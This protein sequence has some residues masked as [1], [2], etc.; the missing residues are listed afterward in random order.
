MIGRVERVIKT[1]KDGL[2]MD[3]KAPVTGDAHADS[4]IHQKWVANYRTAEMQVFY[5]MAFDRI[6]KQV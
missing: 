2:I 3:V 6:V 5:D 1:L 4:S